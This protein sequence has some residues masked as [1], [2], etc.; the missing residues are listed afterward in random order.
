[1]NKI[2]KK[3]LNLLKAFSLPLVIFSTGQA[4]SG[5]EG[6][7]SEIEDDFTL[8]PII[9]P[10]KTETKSEKPAPS[11]GLGFGIPSGFGASFGSAFIGI[12]YGVPT[13]DGLTFYDDDELF[14]FFF[15]EHEQGHRRKGKRH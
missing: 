5:G 9:S 3:N 15:F 1:M 7:P 14:Y 4:H 8:T 10:V 13:V 11:P 12:S 6:L 2:S